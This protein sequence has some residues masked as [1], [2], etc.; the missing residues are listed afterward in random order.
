[1]KTCPL[2]NSKYKRDMTCSNIECDLS[3]KQ[4]TVWIGWKTLGWKIWYWRPRDGYYFLKNHLFSRYDL[5]RTGLPKHQYCDPSYKIEVAMMRILVDFVEGEDVFSHFHLNEHI[6]GCDINEFNNLHAILDLYV[7][8]KVNLPKLEKR[9]DDK[10]TEWCE[11]T[12]LVFDDDPDNP[13]LN[14]IRFDKSPDSDRLSNE[15]TEL[16]LELEKFTT[17][18]L[19][20]LVKHRASFWT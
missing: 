7:D 17:D 2:C 18:I 8:I 5:V 4:K 12:A 3:Y 16:E 9:V 11:C 19:S 15:H 20:R 14:T 10:L 1:M 6:D 13:N